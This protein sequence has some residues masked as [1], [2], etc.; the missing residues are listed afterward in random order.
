MLSVVESLY[1]PLPLPLAGGAQ[2]KGRIIPHVFHRNGKP[3]RTFR[4]TWR[5]ACK[6]ADLPHLWIHD[7]RR[8]A[9]RRLIRSNVPQPIAMRLSGHKTAATFR[10]Y[11][12]VT[13]SDLTEAVRKVAEFRKTERASEGQVTAIVGH[14]LATVD[15]KQQVD[16]TK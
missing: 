5:S 9:V 16:G 6:K 4:G 12:I 11:G 7:L 1:A 14:S 8:S 15:Q 3:I 10:R 2:P 13:E